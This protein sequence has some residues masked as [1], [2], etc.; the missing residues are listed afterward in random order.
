MADAAKFRVSIWKTPLATDDEFF[1]YEDLVGYISITDLLAND[2]GGEAKEFYGIDQDSP[3]VA[4]TT[5]RSHLGALLT[6]NAGGTI[7]YD[8]HDPAY[9]REIQALSEGESIED[10]FTY[11]IRMANGTLSTATVWITVTGQNDAPVFAAETAA[12]DVTELGSNADVGT[13]TTSGSLAFTDTDLLDSH[14]VEVIANNDATGSLTATVTDS[15]TGDGAG[16]VGWEYLS[17]AADL[18]Y[19]AEGETREEAFSVTLRDRESGGLT[20]TATVRVTI[21]GTNDDPVIDVAGSTVSGTVEEFEDGAAGENIETHTVG[22]TVAFSDRDLTDTHTANFTSLGM[23][24]R[25]AFSLLG[26]PTTND[27]TTAGIQ[28]WTFSVDDAEIDDLAAGQVL[29]QHYSVTLDDGKGG[30]ATQ[31]VTLTLTGRNDAPTLA[32]GTARA[33]GGG[34]AVDIDLSALGAD[35]DSDDDGSSLSYA[36][37]GDPTAGTASINGTTLSFDPGG[38]FRELGEGNSR[39]VAIQVQAADTH[40]AVSNIADVTV[41]ITGTDAAPRIINLTNG[42]NDT[43][44]APS[45]SGD[46]SIVAFYSRAS[47][48]VDGQ[49]D[50]NGHTWDVFTYSVSTKTTINITDGGNDHSDGPTVSMDGSTIAFHSRA[51]NLVDGQT[52][53]N[54]NI[55]DIF[56]YDVATGTTTNITNGSNRDS[57]EPSISA[58]GSTIVLNSRATNLVDGQPDANG[59]IADI[60]V[61][62]VAA[63]TTTNITPGGN[64]GSS[65][66][67]VSG[68]GSIIA[69]NSLATNLVDGQTD[70]N[71]RPDIFVY[72]VV[73]D[74]MTNITH[75]GNHESFAPI[76]SMDGSTV[77]FHSNASNLVDGQTDANGNSQDIFI[78][79]VATKTTINI[80]DG[81]N[82]TSREPVLSA[83]GSVI[84]FYS[85]ATN[86]VDDQT[87]SNG[88]IEDIFVYDVATGTMTNITH[89]G[90]GSSAIPSIAANGSII[91][92]DSMATNL[93]DDQ[94]DVNGPT[95][96]VFLYGL[97]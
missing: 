59:S 69:F 96:D 36:I 87:D 10:W 76:V 11:T 72:D 8:A 39:D 30:T 74:V 94:I 48:L 64:A 17:D 60:F 2:L 25:G 27:A 1:G 28:D 78:Y 73:N 9:A 51:S 12:G 40:G 13:L 65:R 83:D 4:S 32:A 29:T 26:A 93:V 37:V 82:Q 92:F 71:S 41:T 66:A 20:D 21:T 34:L 44:S 5:A 85:R 54:G 91:A 68:D 42:G 56:V 81:G 84:A 77:V 16:T 14:W 57:S 19:L 62:D 43:S 97:I 58:D 49:I 80:T 75:G 61:Y 86:L 52:D 31:T 22:G 35:V 90:N 38:A 18:A 46:G 23:G 7:S 24:Y 63:A 55:A 88:V 47:N 70:T 53:A 89:G 15:A 95:H 67:T 79:D 33:V 3:S 6:V 50:A 45:I